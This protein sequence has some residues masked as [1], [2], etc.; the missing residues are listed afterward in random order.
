VMRAKN[1]E[2]VEEGQDEIGHCCNKCMREWIDLETG[3]ERM[4]LHTILLPC[5]DLT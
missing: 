2:V 4:L 3:E 1:L 5:I